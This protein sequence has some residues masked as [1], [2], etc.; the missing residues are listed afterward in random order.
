MTPNNREV[1]RPAKRM[2]AP[3]M[4]SRT[5]SSTGRIQNTGGSGRRSGPRTTSSAAASSALPPRAFA[6]GDRADHARVVSQA[7]DKLR[8][9]GEDSPV[10]EPLARLGEYELRNLTAHLEAAGRTRTSTACYSSRRSSPEPSGSATPGS[11]R[12]SPGARPVRSSLTCAARGDARR[13]RRRARSSTAAQRRAS[14]SRS[15]TRSS[16][17]PWRASPGTSRS[18]CC[19]RWSR[20][21]SGRGGRRLPTRSRRRSSGRDGRARSRRSRPTSP[22]SG[23]TTTRSGSPARSTIPSRGWTH[24]KR[25]LATPRRRCDRAC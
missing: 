3:E 13:R 4:G 20:E 10:S 25:S 2:V 14:R 5:R 12:S 1:G 6:L 15:G 23:C 16:R 18:G 21:V 8:A 19:G 24:L 9:D 22:R 11:T 7:T 17:R